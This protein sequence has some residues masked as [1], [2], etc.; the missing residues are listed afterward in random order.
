MYY[1]KIHLTRR[2]VHLSQNTRGIYFTLK[3]TCIT[4]KKF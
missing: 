2:N 1:N 3:I 4:Y